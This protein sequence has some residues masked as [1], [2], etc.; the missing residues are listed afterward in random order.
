MQICACCGVNNKNTPIDKAHVK[1]RNLFRIGE[2][3]EYKNIIFLCKTCHYKFFDSK[4]Q[5]DLSYNHLGLKKIDDWWYFFK[6]VDSKI[7]I[8]KS[9]TNLD[10]FTDYVDEKNK[11]LNLRLKL[12]IFKYKKLIS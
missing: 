10:I 9:Y 11:V 3:H 4:N 5:Y 1:D 8:T 2:D 7:E 6:L 12:A